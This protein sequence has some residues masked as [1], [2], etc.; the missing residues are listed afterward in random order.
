M[1][2]SSGVKLLLSEPPNAAGDACPCSPAHSLCNTL[3]WCAVE[4]PGVCTQATQAYLVGN[5]AL[6][7]EL[8]AKG[9]EH[10]QKMQAAHAVASEAIYR[11]RNPH[12]KH[13]RTPLLATAAGCT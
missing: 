11:E 12:S 2:L 4:R 8:G 5:K 9:R 7:K 1:C 10:A 13:S 3:G 6:A